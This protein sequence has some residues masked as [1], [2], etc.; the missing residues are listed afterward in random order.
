MPKRGVVYPLQLQVQC[1]VLFYSDVDAVLNTSKENR[2]LRAGS[3]C[4]PLTF[5]Q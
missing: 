4:Q 3:E 5:L 1:L 2:C